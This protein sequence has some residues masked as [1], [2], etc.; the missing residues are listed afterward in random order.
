MLTNTFMSIWVIVLT[1][2]TYYAVVCCYIEVGSSSWTWYTRLSAILIEWS[3]WRTICRRIYTFFYIVIRTH[4]TFKESIIN[5]VI[6]VWWGNEF[7]GDTSTCSIIK[8]LACTTYPSFLL[9]ELYSFVE[10]T[11]RW[12]IDLSYATL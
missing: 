8:V 1:K 11:S 2:A 12:A 6:L 10:I 4:I 9:T 5:K 3:A 7:S